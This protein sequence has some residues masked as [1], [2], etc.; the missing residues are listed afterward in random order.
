MRK[1]LILAFL[2][3][4][5]L[6]MAQVSI[7]D[8][9]YTTDP[10]DGTYPSPLLNQ[11][12]T[13]QG[14]VTA[15]NFNFSNGLNKFFIQDG[16]GPFSGIYVF[17]WSTVVQIGDLVEVRGKVS[18]YYGFTELTY[19][20]QITILSSGNP[21][22]SPVNLST[23]Q[24]SN[25]EAYESMLVKIQNL[26][27]TSAQD[28]HG[29]WYVTDG[30]GPCQIDDGFFYFD[31]ANITI[32]QGQTW[33]QITGIVDYSYDAFGLNPRTP[34]DLS[35]TPIAPRTSWGKVKSMYK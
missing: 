28:S 17:D 18:E 20:E 30:S 5:T 23:L 2:A 9:Q 12:V 19:V 16:N 29:E 11:I 33:G 1:I 32:A 15:V 24:I 31:D 6:L 8:I 26:T 10:G 3:I 7:Y 13:T 25:S 34:A 35:L 14:V 21:V 22:P 27:V 4:G